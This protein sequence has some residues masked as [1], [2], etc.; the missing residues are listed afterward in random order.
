LCLKAQK[1]QYFGHFI[2]IAAQ[3]DP[4]D[5]DFCWGDGEGRILLFTHALVLFKRQF[6]VFSIVFGD[7]K[8]SFGY[9][10]KSATK[11]MKLD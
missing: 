11:S 3:S 7:L 2:E 1:Q 4:D 9:V 10:S 6:V 5:V 8:R